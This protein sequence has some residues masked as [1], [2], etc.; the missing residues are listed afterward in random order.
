MSTGIMMNNC[1]VLESTNKLLIKIVNIWLMADYKEQRKKRCTYGDMR[2][3]KG[4][5]LVIILL[6]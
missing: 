1:L 3:E 5:F 2:I 4:Q 6:L